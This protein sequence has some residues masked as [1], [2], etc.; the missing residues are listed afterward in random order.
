MGE[1]GEEGSYC[2]GWGEVWAGDGG[3]FEWGEAGGGGACLRGLFKSVFR[4]GGLLS[5]EVSSMASEG[6]LKLRN[7]FSAMYLI[8]SQRRE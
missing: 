7:G 3:E 4:A 6:Y 8:V 5:R 2:D 1:R